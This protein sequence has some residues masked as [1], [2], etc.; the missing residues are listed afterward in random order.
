[1]RKRQFVGP[2][3]RRI[4]LAELGP[5]TASARGEL[6]TALGGHDAM[7]RYAVALALGTSGVDWRNKR[8]AKIRLPRSPALR[9]SILGR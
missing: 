9:L 1:M 6:T 8:S 4:G 7:T 2:N 3:N 5:D